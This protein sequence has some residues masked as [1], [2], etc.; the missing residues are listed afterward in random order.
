MKDSNYIAAFII[1]LLSTGFIISL[2]ACINEPTIPP[3]AGKIIVK[4]SGGAGLLIKECSDR[5]YITQTA[6]YIVEGTVEKVESS[7]NEDRT[8][9]FTYTTLG[10]DNYEKGTPFAGNEL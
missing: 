2:S 4:Q 3:P 9:I 5:S 1:M 7:W 6:D 8:G 10:I